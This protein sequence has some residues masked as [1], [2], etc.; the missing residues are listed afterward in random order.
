[1]TL[2]SWMVKRR[3]KKRRDIHSTN[4]KHDVKILVRVIRTVF[5]LWR[6]PSVVSVSFFR[7]PP[8]C[9]RLNYGFFPTIA[10]ALKSWNQNVSVPDAREQIW[11]DVVLFFSRAIYRLNSLS[12]LKRLK[13]LVF[14][15][16]CQILGEFLYI[17]TT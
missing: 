15:A 13:S 6:V 10:D 7:E 4:F 17:F 11:K 16:K 1:M 5:F 14:H 9:C 8:H 2:V 3:K 12:E